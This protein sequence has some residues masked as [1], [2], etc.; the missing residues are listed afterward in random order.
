[1]ENRT[2]Q[3]KYYRIVRKTVY[4]NRQRSAAHSN[5]FNFDQ[6]VVDTADREMRNRLASF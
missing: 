1:M 2:F 5:D 3:T 4:Q 6:A